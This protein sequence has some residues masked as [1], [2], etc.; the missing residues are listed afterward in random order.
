MTALHTKLRSRG[1]EILAFPCNQ[2]RNQEPGTNEEIAAFARGKYGAEYPIMAKSDVNGPDA[3]QA[4]QFL[5]R[6]SSLYD[7]QKQVASEIPWNFAKFLVDK[8]GQV[9][10]YY[11]PIVEPESLIPEIEKMLQ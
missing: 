3:N 7:Q 10:N 11:E 9:V 1:F 2:F 6:H 8:H 4:Y 5:R